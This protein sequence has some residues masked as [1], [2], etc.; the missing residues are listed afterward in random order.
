MHSNGVL[1]VISLFLSIE[2]FTVSAIDCIA[3][4]YVVSY[5]IPGILP[6]ETRLSTS[7]SGLIKSQVGLFMSFS[8]PEQYGGG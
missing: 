7:I 5:I 3:F 1:I 4:L 8:S 6:G 2:S